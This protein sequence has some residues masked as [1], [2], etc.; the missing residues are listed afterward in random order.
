MIDGFVP[1]TLGSRHGVP[2]TNDS[3]ARHHARFGCRL[4]LAV[5]PDPAILQLA[6]TG[7]SILLQL[8][9]MVTEQ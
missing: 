1:G 4:D 8:T 9:K 7:A 5:V 6:N 3:P 2:L